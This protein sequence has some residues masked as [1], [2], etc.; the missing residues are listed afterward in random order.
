MICL[1]EAPFDWTDRKTIKVP[2]YGL[3][4]IAGKLD[5]VPYYVDFTIHQDYSIDS[6]PKTALYGF[7]VMRPNFRSSISMARE[8][9]KRDPHCK[10]IFGGPSVTD[11]GKRIMDNECV[12]YCIEGMNEN[13]FRD[14]VEGK[15]PAKI[16]NLIYRKDRKAIENRKE[17]VPK[18]WE[19]IMPGRLNQVIEG[20][21]RDDLTIVLG[22]LGCSHKCRFCNITKSQPIFAERKDR[23]I[24]K[25]IKQRGK[26]DYKLQIMHQNFTYR[27]P[28][29]MEKLRKSELLPSSIAFNSRP[30]TFLDNKEEFEETLSE[31]RDTVF[32]LYTGIEN[33]DNRELKRLGK[34]ITRE[35][36]VE[37]TKE[38]IELEKKHDNF[39]FL[40]SFIGYNHKTTTDNLNN[41]QKVLKELFVDKRE[42]K[43]IHHFFESGL[44]TSPFNGDYPE[45]IFEVP[46]DKETAD[47]IN[48]Y[49][50]LTQDLPSFEE[51]KYLYLE[52][53]IDPFREPSLNLPWAEIYCMENILNNR[54]DEAAR[55]IKECKEE[56]KSLRIG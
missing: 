38:L 51:R 40:L 16:P 22:S 36:N 4:R 35:K 2:N 8:L 19:R 25:E 53:V 23:H 24:I 1:I 37:A 13:S 27:L 7:S 15:E 46:E 17:P 21:Y 30:D 41:N 47:K 34:D 50:F 6:V 56:Y 12:D 52:S 42:L 20:R 5:E 33:Y 3:E 32:V 48:R 14:L 10:I 11:L 26:K 18:G 43:P 39:D 54:F 49:L 44:R 9:K 31:F 55:K 28:G 45:N 29:F